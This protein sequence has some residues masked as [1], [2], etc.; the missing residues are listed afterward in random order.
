MASKPTIIKFNE[1][2]GCGV[3]AKILFTNKDAE[4]T[5][6]K[7]RALV[8]FDYT[9]LTTMKNKKEDKTYT[10]KVNNFPIILDNEAYT[11][12]FYLLKADNG[13]EKEVKESFINE[14]IM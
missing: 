5:L 13:V 3:N 9:K 12:G 11:L 2:L 14:D 8:S 1:I 10:E 7:G 4:I 6:P